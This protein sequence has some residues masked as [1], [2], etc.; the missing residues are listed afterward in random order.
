MVMR[1]PTLTSVESEVQSLASVDY[2]LTVFC[3]HGYH[4]PASGSTVIQLSARTE[5]DSM[6]LR[7]GA[8][9]HT[10]ILDCC[11]VVAKPMLRL[12]EDMIAK[13]AIEA[14]T[15]HPEDCRRYFDRAISECPPGIVV[16]FGCSVGQT[17][18]D[19]QADGG[20]YS[21][22]LLSAAEA[23][24]QQ[25]S[26]DAEKYYRCLSV[27]QAHERA[28]PKVSDL[29][30]GRQTPTLERPRSSPCFPFCIIA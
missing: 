3:G 10:L 13:R 17:A 5:L 1:Q 15:I 25:T 20:Y 29:S 26:V 18:G 30:G 23:W 2:S 8:A 14:S 27:V 28:L 7:K 4:A 6:K 22:S 21:Y 11:R 24:G 16:L 9:R 12:T 19:S